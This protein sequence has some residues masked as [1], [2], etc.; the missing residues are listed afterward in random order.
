LPVVSIILPDW[1]VWRLRAHPTPAPFLEFDPNARD[2]GTPPETNLPVPR[3]VERD[4]FGPQD[5]AEDD[6]PNPTA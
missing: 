3:V 1:P 5:N 6:Q 2:L 4:A